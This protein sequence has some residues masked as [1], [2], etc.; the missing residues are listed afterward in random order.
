MYFIVLTNLLF[1]ILCHNEGFASNLVS[2]KNVSSIS[3]TTCSSSCTTFSSV[4][5][6]SA[7]L[8]ATVAITFS[9]LVSSGSATIEFAIMF[10]SSAV[11]TP[12]ISSTG[13][14]IYFRASAISIPI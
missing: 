3:E 7:T 2:S 12:I 14:G 1:L 9:S 10:S 5:D 13:V 11:L 8:F 6:S 4:I